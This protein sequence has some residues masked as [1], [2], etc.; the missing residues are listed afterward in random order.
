MNNKFF[1]SPSQN[2]S[3]FFGLFL[4]AG[5]SNAQADDLKV[6]TV[7]YPLQYFAQSIG[8][9]VVK[10]ALPMPEDIDPAFWSPT[11]K[12]VAE[13]QKADIILLNGAHYAKWLPKVSLPLS[14]RAFRWY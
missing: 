9:H 1:F 14:K 10:V 8:G 5:F 12:D 7:N 4:A 13:I 3:L 11:A 6:S 2:K